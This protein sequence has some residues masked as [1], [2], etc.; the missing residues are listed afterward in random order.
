MDV[1]TFG[2]IHHLQVLRRSRSTRFFFGNNNAHEQK[3]IF[4]LLLL[5][6]LI[7]TFFYGVFTKSK[8]LKNPSSVKIYHV[9]INICK[10]EK[11]YLLIARVG[12][13][14]AEF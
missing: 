11:Q 6:T 2:T 1:L 5:F 8:R 3:D 13:C 10:Y 14:K 9:E 7:L 4:K 12:I